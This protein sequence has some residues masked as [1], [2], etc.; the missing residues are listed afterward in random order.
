MIF[1]NIDLTKWARKVREMIIDMGQNNRRYG[2]VVFYIP[3]KGMRRE[4]RQTYFFVMEKKRRK[5]G[6]IFVEGKYICL[7]RKRKRREIFEEGKCIFAE[8]KKNG[9]GKGGKYLAKE[10]IF[11]FR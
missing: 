11:F 6:N 7:W 9:G 4:R 5:R 1:E 10:N 3:E 8:A 2:K